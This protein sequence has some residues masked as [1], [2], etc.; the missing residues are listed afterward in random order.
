V[1]SSGKYRRLVEAASARGF[2][3]RMIY[4]VLDTLERQLERIKVR[5]A[6]GGHDVPSDKVAARRTRSFEQ[7]AW[8][9]RHVDRCMVFANSGDEP[10]LAAASVS[11]GPLW[12]FGE[13]PEDLERTLATSRVD[14]R[15]AE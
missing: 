5:V 6:S 14:V 11:R 7:L 13:L 15:D 1:L 12:R 3:T 10:E 4:V 2:E 9:A 8:F